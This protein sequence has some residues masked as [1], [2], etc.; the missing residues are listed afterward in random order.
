MTSENLKARHRFAVVAIVIAA[1]GAALPMGKSFAGPADN[2]KAAGF[3]EQVVQVHTKD[4]IVASGALF[5]PPKDVAKP[6]AVIWIHGWGLNFYSPT[7]VAISRALAKRGYST[8]HVLATWFM[9]LSQRSH[10]RSAGRAR[11]S[12]LCKLRVRHKRI[13]S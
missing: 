6:V 7:Y 2:Q 12:M 8:I 5:A 3:A 11:T 13:T 9:A 10:P 1:I 4:D